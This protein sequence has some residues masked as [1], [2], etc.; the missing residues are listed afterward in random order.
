MATYFSVVHNDIQ[1]YQY[2]Y[3]VSLIIKKKIE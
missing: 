3:F 2:N 1:K